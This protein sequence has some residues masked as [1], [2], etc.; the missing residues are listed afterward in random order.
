[1]EKLQQYKEQPYRIRQHIE[2]YRDDLALDDYGTLAD[3]LN[4]VYWEQI[5]KLV[6]NQSFRTE[7]GPLLERLVT[8]LKAKFPGVG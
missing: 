2:S 5:L 7:G 3:N 8:Y 4:L 6:Q 1:M